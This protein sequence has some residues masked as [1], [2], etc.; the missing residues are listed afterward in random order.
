MLT[1]SATPNASGQFPLTGT[2]AIT[3][4]GCAETVSVNGTVSG[5][6]ITLASAPAPVVGQ[7]Y[8]SFAGSTNPTATQLTASA[9]VFEPIP[10]ST[11][12]GAPTSTVTFTGTLTGQ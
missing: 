5:V 11:G 4:T 10:C 12:P 8:V 7:N 6:G 3:G 2:L 9:I 1:Q